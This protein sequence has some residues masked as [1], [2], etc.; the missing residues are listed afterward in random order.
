[1]LAAGSGS[2]SEDAVRSAVRLTVDTLV[3]TVRCARL[4]PDQLDDVLLVG[5]VGEVPLIEQM[6]RAE[7][8]NRVTLAA[9]PQFTAAIGAARAASR[10]LSGPVSPVPAQRS[11]PVYEPTGEVSVLDGLIPRPPVNITSLKLPRR[12]ALA[13]ARGFSLF[14]L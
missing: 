2:P 8:P 6:V 5:E 13:S 1:M 4:Q 7:F 11:T 10:L 9:E 14:G 12:R 3:W